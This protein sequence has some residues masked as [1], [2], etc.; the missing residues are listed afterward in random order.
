VSLVH[1]HSGPTPEEAETI[2]MNVTVRIYQVREVRLRWHG[3]FDAS[4][5]IEK[6]FADELE[7]MET[8]LNGSY[9]SAYTYFEEEP[10]ANVSS[11]CCQ[12]R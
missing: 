2:G 9:S 5:A 8:T 10:P 7:E 6:E 3:V 1:R 11:R 4:T 12:C